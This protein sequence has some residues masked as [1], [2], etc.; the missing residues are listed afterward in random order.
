M[1]ALWEQGDIYLDQYEGW[2]CV[3][4]ERFWT[5]KDLVDGRCP[6]CLR[7]A[8][9]ITEAN[10]FFRM[11]SYQNW[12]IVYIQTHPEFIRPESCRNEVLGFLR[13]P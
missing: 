5:E 3:L 8:E 13:Q 10:Y 9:Q 4:D 12:L 7:P 6:D 1:Q 11:S 2:Y